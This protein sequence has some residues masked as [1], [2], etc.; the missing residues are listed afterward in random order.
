MASLRTV[1][2]LEP[3]VLLDAHRGVIHDATEQLRAKIAWTEETIG[4]IE[5]L[6][7]CGVGAREIVRRLFDAES[8]VGWV[9]AGE[10]SRKSFVQAVLREAGLARELARHDQVNRT[11][12]SCSLSFHS[13]SRDVGIARAPRGA[14]DAPAPAEARAGDAFGA[15]RSCSEEGCLRARFWGEQRASPHRSQQ[16]RAEE[17]VLPHEV[18]RHEPGIDAVGRDAGAG[19]ARGELVG[20]Q[21]VGELRLRVG[22]QADPAPFALQVVEREAAEPLEHR[23]DDDD[24]RTTA[25][26]AAAKRR[27][28]L[29]REQKGREVVH[30]EGELDAIG[31]E[32]AAR[33]IDSRVVHEHVDGGMARRNLRGGRQ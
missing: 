13:R 2:A 8:L 21:H 20:E 26:G 4:R 24:A 1:A 32:R 12:V 16:A 33:R 17:H 27:E 6:G 28:Q 19:E 5:E 3:R 29:V 9:S 10:Y 15:R 18:R 22:E 11:P 14:H 7:V 23:G 25:R 31:A 30:R